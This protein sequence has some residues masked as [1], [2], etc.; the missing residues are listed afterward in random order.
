M[1]TY[2]AMASHHPLPR[3]SLAA[4]L[5]PDQPERAARSSLSQAL[6]TL[7]G[8]L[9][10]KTTLESVLWA[11]AESVRLNP[12]DIQVDVTEFLSLLHACESHHHHSWRTCTP[13][14]LRLLQATALYQ[15]DFLAGFSIADSAT[16]EEW[17][18]LQRE[19][20][21][22]RALS[23]LQHLAEWQAWRGRYPEAIETVRR[24]VDLEPFLEVNQRHL[25][26]LLALNG[27]QAA[28]QAHYR[29]LQSML[30]REL[31]IEPEA[32]T[33]SL[34]AQSLQGGLSGM[35]RRPPFAVPVP[36]AS[37]VGRAA[38][39]E[40]ICSSLQE[41]V[42]LL[43]I[44]GTGGMGKTRLAL[45]TAHRLH[46]DFEDGVHYVAL[47]PL[48]DPL[49]VGT[50]IAHAL[51]V[52]ER[53]G[54][55]SLDTLQAYLRSKH[56]LLVLDNFE[57]VEQAATL[58][59]D[60]LASCPGIKF[61]VTSRKPLNL[62]AEQQYPLDSL[63]ED[64]AL[65]LYEQRAQA[66][67]GRIASEEDKSIGREICRRLDGM[68]LAIE[69]CAARARLHTPGEMLRQIEKPL[70]V[71]VSGPRDLPERHQ[72]LRKAI[73]WSYD[74][75][76]PEQQPVF[77]HLGLFAGGCTL[78]TAQS[79]MGADTDL[80]P[81]LEALQQASLLQIQTVAGERRFSMLE[82]LREF[83]LE[84]LAAQGEAAAARQRH[85]EAYLD[86]AELARP[87]LD[88]AD[89]KA[90]FDRLSREL[91]N[92]RLALSWSRDCAI[93]TGLRLATTLDVFWSV[94]GYSLE[95]RK[96]LRDALQS[97][98]Q[99][100]T[101]IQARGFL[102]AGALAYLQ[103]DYQEAHE[104]LHQSH[105]LCL[106]VENTAGFARVLYFLGLAAEEQA[107]YTAAQGYLQ[108]SL[109]LSR[110]VKDWHTEAG[111]LNGM[112]FIASR[113]GD[114]VLS[115][116]YDEQALSLYRAHNAIRDIA[117]LTLN[118]GI[119]AYEQGDHKTAREY[120]E[121]A[122]AAA[123][124]YGDHYLITLSRLNLGN[125]QVAQ[126]DYAAARANLE[127]SIA[128]QKAQGDTIS[129]D[130]QLG[131]LGRALHKLGEYR[132]ARAAQAEAL[133]IRAST[134]DRRGVAVSLENLAPVEHSE[135]QPGRAAHLLGAAEAI[136]EA[137]H[138]PVL[139]ARRSEYE[140]LV[141]AV[142][143]ALGEAAFANAWAAGRTMTPEQAV[144]F[145]TQAEVSYHPG[146]G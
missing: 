40:D 56:L 103:G 39:L 9:G 87:E 128:R 1:L 116:S 73:Q 101:E 81:I 47:A 28:A 85:A 88:G 77:R 138:A 119:D 44:T 95:A 12:E 21:L 96:W 139:P 41:G 143:G 142:R 92:L 120:T 113:Q 65:Q 51:G 97:S 52:K 18:G 133:S 104:N 60:L 67:G 94:A 20:L 72:T 80:L 19:H 26:R 46:Y 111:S 33:A 14:A 55:S 3:L 57:H 106:Q 90:W 130:A 62:R 102:V 35:E 29:Q 121:T 61:L 69:L 10:E 2:L 59:A 84:Q 100:P 43:T 37:F 11:D 36:P 82:T 34:Y 71:L 127:E 115:R 16:F 66:A 134:G 30:D 58:V 48:N 42:R 75:L 24:Q 105:A 137:I 78:E 5:W 112:A 140:Q 93:E 64:E 141:G 79:V 83:A 99:V 7:R 124:E 4:L 50:A 91:A 125:V 135:G 89:Q 25:L 122:L 108:E 63:A 98:Q 109:R 68:P 32:E 54:L 136:R 13:C 107:N 118:L 144:E 74:L 76:P 15:G 22:Q 27:E 86:L 38:E 146:I 123:L 49:L 126:G 114:L 129:L 70:Q 45:E 110:E 131:V 17:A 23:A 6:A 132:P 53:P 117:G 8:A 31:G 145:A